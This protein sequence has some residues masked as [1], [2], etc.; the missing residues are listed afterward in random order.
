[1]QLRVR[2]KYCF[3]ELLLIIICS[4]HLDAHLKPYRC[5][6]EACLNV[7]FSS[8]AC[9]LRHEREAHG[10]HGHGDKPYLCTFEDCE[11]RLPGN[12]FP[13][14]WNLQDHMKR[15]HDYTVPPLNEDASPAFEAAT[16]RTSR[17]KK[18]VV[19]LNGSVAKK[20][21]TA[22]IT[23]ANSRASAPARQ[24]LSIQKQFQNQ[25]AAA[26]I[27]WTDARTQEQFVDMSIL[28]MN[29]ANVAGFY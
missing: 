3:R 16:I 19:P 8:T 28:R 18:A 4:K 17:K 20:P 10:M 21:K 27:Q 26:E 1:M 12:G 13:R 2:R 23:K 22:T 7:P 29:D 11:R 5:K 15:V 24:R 25:M 14:R 9:L 6:A